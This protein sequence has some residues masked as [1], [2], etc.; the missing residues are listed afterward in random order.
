MF[1]LPKMLLTFRSE[2][3]WV[4]FVVVS[5]LLVASQVVLFVPQ[6]LVAVHDSPMEIGPT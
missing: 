4:E 2:G 6:T 5:F 3:V 1:F